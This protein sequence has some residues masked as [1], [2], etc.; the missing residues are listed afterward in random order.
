VSILQAQDTQFRLAESGSISYQEQA[1]NPLPGIEIAKLEKG[2]NI[3]APKITFVDADILNDVDKTALRTHVEAWFATHLKTVLEPL[4]ALED[5]ENLTGAA[6]GIAFQVHEDM[7]IVPREQLEGLIADL[8]TDMRRDLRGKK[9]RLGPILV[10]IPALNKPAAVRLRALLWGLSHGKA[11]PMDVPKDGIVS[12]AVDEAAVDKGFYQSIGYPVFGGRAIR[13][14]ML[15]RVISAVYDAAE[16]GQFKAEHKMAEW[17]GSSIEALYAVLEAM[18]HKKVS[19]PADEVKAE[20]ADAAK[21]DVPAEEVK[22]EEPKEEAAEAV[23]NEKQA[24]DVKPELAVFRLKKGKAFQKSGG[25][26]KPY[27]KKDYKKSDAKPKKGKR[28]KTQDRQPKIMSTGPEKKLEDS[29]FAVL[30]QLQKNG[31]E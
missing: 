29:P 6:K 8:D 13:I 24:S 22:A 1:S 23:K 28:S 12:F 18:G 14:D 9:V 31:N 11:L 19:D 20:G 15:D 10:F 3:L 4:V 27:A 16:N 25:T 17:L 7:G 21:A 26:K 30:A 5:D 2:D